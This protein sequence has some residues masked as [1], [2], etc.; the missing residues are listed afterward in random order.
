MVQ[1][2][3]TIFSSFLRDLV[4]DVD[5]HIYKPTLTSINTHTHI[6]IHMSTF[7]KNIKLL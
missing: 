5:S 1:S 4:T 3:P 2:I 7:K 6:L